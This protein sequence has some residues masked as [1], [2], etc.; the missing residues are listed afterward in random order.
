M[1]EEDPIK[2]LIEIA[3]ILDELKIDY[4]VTGGFAITIW[5]KPRFTADIDIVIK[6]AEFHG[7]IF[8]DKIQAIFPTGYIDKSQI[9]SALKSIGQFNFIEPGSGLKMD[10]YITKQ[11]DFEK[12]CFKRSK[13]EDLGYQIKIISP[14]N[15]ILSKLIW[16]R[17]AQSDRH[18]EDIK[19]VLDTRNIDQK[20][21]NSWVKKLG[22]EKEWEKAEELLNHK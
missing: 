8:A 10:F 6:M 13:A 19:S 3:K 4:Y 22:L 5:G 9:K 16:Y 2:V 11:N 12:E 7:G 14:E 21:L 1:I 17:E 15:L 18:L 20:Y